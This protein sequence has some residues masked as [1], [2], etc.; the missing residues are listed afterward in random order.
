MSPIGIATAHDVGCHGTDEVTDATAK[1][2]SVRGLISRG[3]IST[4]TISME[5]EDGI[6]R[7]AVSVLT[8]TQDGLGVQEADRLAFCGPEGDTSAQYKGRR[9]CT[10]V[11]SSRWTRCFCAAMSCP[12]LQ[13]HQATWQE[14][15]TER[16][17]D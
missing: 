6:E 16:K 1:L 9:K 15:S 5:A 7:E 11:S 4:D 3:W 8:Q 13:G 2:R 10:A 14:S 17:W 12:S